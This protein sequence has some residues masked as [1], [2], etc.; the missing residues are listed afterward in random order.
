MY[1][2]SV[3]EKTKME[4]NMSRDEMMR[5]RQDEDTQPFLGHLTLQ[6]HDEPEQETED[7]KR[8]ET[9]PE[10]SPNQSSDQKRRKQDKTSRD[11]RK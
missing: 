7:R 8:R 11:N 3:G 5:H 10:K 6:I 4:A 2:R 9:G 1:R